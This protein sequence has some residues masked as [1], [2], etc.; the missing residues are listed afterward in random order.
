MLLAI[1]TIA[2][3]ASSSLAESVSLPPLISTSTSL[4]VATAS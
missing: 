3:A 2:P 1:H 4:A